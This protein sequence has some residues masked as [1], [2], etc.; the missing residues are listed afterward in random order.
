MSANTDSDKKR[1]EREEELN[2]LRVILKLPEGRRIIW[3]LLG[4]CSVFESIWDPSSR[5]H[6]NAGR[7]D[8]GH[9]ILGEVTEAD[10][11]SLLKMMKEAK[12]KKGVS[13]V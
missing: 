13:D 11:E 2:D 9:F 8:V 12:D 3:R 7:Q 6:K 10:D 5:I 1:N 4:H